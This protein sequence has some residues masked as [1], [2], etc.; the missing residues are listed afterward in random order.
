MSRY[1]FNYKNHSSTDLIYGLMLIWKQRVDGGLDEE[2]IVD[3]C[4]D[5]SYI[6]DLIIIGMKIFVKSKKIIQCLMSMGVCAIVVLSNLI[7]KVK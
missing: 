1:K 4:C 5:E 7:K 6:G 2:D 3:D